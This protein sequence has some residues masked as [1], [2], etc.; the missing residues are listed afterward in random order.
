MNEIVQK[1]IKSTYS[2]IDILKDSDKSKIELVYDRIAKQVCVIKYLKDTDKDIYKNLRKIKHR[3]LPQIYR[4]FEDGENL[5][6]IEEYIN[7]QTLEEM[8]K[9]KLITSDM[10]IEEILIQLCEGLAVLHKRQIVYRDIKPAN[11]M[12]NNDNI[13]KLIDFDI[14]RVFKETKDYDTKL[15]GTKGYVAPEQVLR[16]SDDRSDIYSLGILLKYLKPTSKVLQQI[17]KKA[18]QIDPENRYQSVEEILAELHGK[19]KPLTM[20]PITD[21][22]TTLK[23][24]FALFQVPIP[25]Q[26]RDYPIII[27]DYQTIV[28][29]ETGEFTSYETY[30]EAYEA[31]LKEFDRLIY[32]YLDEHI[33]DILDYYKVNCLKKYYDYQRDKTNFYYQINLQIERILAGIDKRFKLNL[34]DYLKHFELVPSFT[35]LMGSEDKQN[36]HL[37]QLKHVDGMPYVGEIQQEFYRRTCSHSAQEFAIYCEDM[38]DTNLKVKSTSLEVPISKWWG[39]KHSMKKITNYFF[40]VDDLYLK[41]FE[42]LVNSTYVVMHNNPSLQEDVSGLIEKSYKPEL[43]QALKQKIIEIL[44][45]IKHKQSQTD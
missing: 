19:Y 24:H 43:Q 30:E 2:L 5:I 11:V 12:V 41:C 4:L 37:W 21:I 15:L 20:L 13:V 32:G 28:P 25:T 3:I 14:A 33:L 36:F 39:L 29:A 45:Y 38:Y 9:N 35:R 6:V 27:G 22:E 16:Q 40:T 17:I 42:E 7:G 34:P 26:E 44:D 23:Q 10:I 31:G 8:L 18:T 1:Y